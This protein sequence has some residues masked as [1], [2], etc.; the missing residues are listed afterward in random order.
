MTNTAVIYKYEMIP[1]QVVELRIPSSAK[2]VHVGMNPATGN[3]A[4]W[5]LLYPNREVVT[6][7]FHTVGTG[8]FF[9]PDQAK[10]FCGTAICGDFIWHVLEVI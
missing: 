6:R 1:D 5:V 3:P 9:D 2:V 4:I 7:R 8:W 10:A